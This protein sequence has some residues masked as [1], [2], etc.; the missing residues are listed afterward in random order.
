[1]ALF[2]LLSDDT[3]DPGSLFLLWHHYHASRSPVGVTSPSQVGSCS[4][5]QERKDKGS[6]G[7]IFPSHQESKSF[8]R[9]TL[10]L[11]DAFVLACA[12]RH[13]CVRVHWP[14]KYH[15]V[16]LSYRRSW[17]SDHLSFSAPAVDCTKGKGEE[18]G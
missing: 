9:T 7:H 1:M 14:E 15:R 4:S 17:E 2:Q 18:D 6:T 8:P 5:K 3:I 10:L 16:P 13:A 12:C 11:L